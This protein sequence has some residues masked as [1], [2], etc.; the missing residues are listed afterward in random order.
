[1]GGIHRQPKTQTSFPKRTRPRISPS[2]IREFT[3]VLRTLQATMP[4][5]RSLLD[6][7]R[8]R[9][10]SRSSLSLGARSYTTKILNKQDPSSRPKL[11]LPTAKSKELAYPNRELVGTRSIPITPVA[12]TL[13]VDLALV[14]LPPGTPVFIWRPSSS[15]E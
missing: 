3:S 6:S 15:P 8:L 14:H 9:G 2:Q 10:R 1:M 12:S 5:S 7:N 4:V 11:H 13:H